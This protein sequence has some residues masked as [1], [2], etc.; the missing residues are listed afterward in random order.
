M[1]IRYQAQAI[2]VSQVYFFFQRGQISNSN[3]KWLM[4]AR[5]AP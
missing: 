3:K 1:L 5:G 4:K 2:Y